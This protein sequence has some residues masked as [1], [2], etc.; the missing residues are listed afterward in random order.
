MSKKRKQRNYTKEQKAD[1]VRYYLDGN[2]SYSEAAKA[3]GIAQS[4]LIGWVKQAEIDSGNGPKGAL[5]TEEKTEI[6]KLR[7]ELKQVKLENAFLKKAAV[8]FAKGTE[9]SK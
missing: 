9:N 3:L 7:R 8:Y 1:A 2:E 4:T 5:T 6:N